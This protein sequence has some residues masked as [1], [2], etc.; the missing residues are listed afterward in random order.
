MGKVSLIKEL[1]LGLID[2]ILATFSRVVHWLSRFFNFFDWTPARYGLSHC[3]LSHRKLLHKS[4]S[5]LSIV[6]VR[7]VKY[8]GASFELV[9]GATC[10][11]KSRETL[12]SFKHFSEFFLIHDIVSSI[13][14]FNSA[15]FNLT[16]SLFYESSCMSIIINLICRLIEHF[17]NAILVLREV[18]EL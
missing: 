3:P 12:L 11:K 16:F 4:E 9:N 10:S 17:S 15:V 2:I 8:W 5:L 7:R 14:A 13:L 6:R 1:F 18:A